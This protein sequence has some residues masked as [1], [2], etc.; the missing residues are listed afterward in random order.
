MDFATAHPWQFGLCCF[1]A[2]YWAATWL[3]RRAIRR[4]AVLHPEI[5]DAEIEA[6]AREG[7]HV[8]AIRLYR[9][10]SGAGLRE[11][12]AAVDAILQRIGA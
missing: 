11:A 9:R 2:G 3:H 1:L 8:D 10:R 4:P 5:S 6:A 12:K 7:R